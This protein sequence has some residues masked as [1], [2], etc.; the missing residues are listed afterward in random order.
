MK[1]GLSSHTLFFSLPL[2]VSLVVVSGGW[3]I[4]TYRHIYVKNDLGNNILLIAHCES[5]NRDIGVQNLNY[6]QEF[7]FQFQVDISGPTKYNCSLTWDDKLHRFDVYD[8]NRDGNQCKDCKW[9]IQK[10]RPC[11]FNFDTQKYDLCDYS[12]Y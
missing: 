2:L 9:N 5:G 11:R 1:V 7:K 10:D 6:Q 4:F 12:Y 3:S 8:S